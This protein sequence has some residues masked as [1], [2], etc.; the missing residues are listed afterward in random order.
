MVSVMSKY[1]Q[2]GSLVCSCYDHCVYVQLQNR[3][4]RCILRVSGCVM[5]GAC[6]K[7]WQYWPM[8]VAGNRGGNLLLFARIKFNIT[9]TFGTQFNEANWFSYQNVTIIVARIDS[10][11]LVE[12]PAPWKKADVSRGVAKYI[13]QMTA[14]RLSQVLF[15][16]LG[17]RIR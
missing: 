10:L 15:S 2:D 17:V 14:A 3:V 4:L 5:S 7:E 16:D 1:L 8:V 9:K 13:L 12:F 11:I 6:H